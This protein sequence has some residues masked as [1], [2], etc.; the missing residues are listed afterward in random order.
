MR[1]SITDLLDYFR[2]F[3][4]ILCFARFYWGRIHLLYLLL[5]QL[6]SVGMKLSGSIVIPTVNFTFSLPIYSFWFY[7]LSLSF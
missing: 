6:A 2:V 4:D 1:V 7:R 5:F 3:L